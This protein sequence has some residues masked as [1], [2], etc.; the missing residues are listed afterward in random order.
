MQSPLKII[1]YVIYLKEEQTENFQTRDQLYESL[2][3]EPPAIRTMIALYL[4]GHRAKNTVGTQTDTTSV[5]IDKFTMNQL[6]QF[7]MN[8]FLKN[9]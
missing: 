3:D 1:S 5:E 4:E 2:D 7:A 6:F 9:S 8:V